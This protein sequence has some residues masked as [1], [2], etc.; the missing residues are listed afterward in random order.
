MNYLTDCI[1]EQVEDLPSAMSRHD[2]SPYECLC[3]RRPEVL[4][5]TGT[6]MA[7]LAIYLFSL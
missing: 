4:P 1:P 3:W 2:H 6:S 5:M 7:S